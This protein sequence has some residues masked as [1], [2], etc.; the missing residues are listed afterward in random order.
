ME[1]LLS[2]LIALLVY[3]F[4]LLFCL[5]AATTA[6][7]LV[8]KTRAARWFALAA[9]VLLLVAGNGRLAYTLV[10]S[11]ENDY[12]PV[13]VDDAPASDVIIVL[14]GGLG[15]PLP[16]RLY[17][18]L[19]SSSDRLL[20]AF[21]LYRAGKAGKILLSGG[22]VFPQPGLEGESFYARQLLE[23]WGVPP[24]AVITETRSRNTLQNA[25]YSAPILA[26]NGWDDVLLVTSASHMSRAV[27][28][29]R[30][31]GVDVVPIPTDFDAVDADIPEIF[32]WLPTIGALG[33]TTQAVHEYIG[34]VYYWWRT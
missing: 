30:H 19:G 33:G 2:K 20:E 27:L 32:S 17:V 29:F 34:R 7:L 4:G 22:N 24:D 15:L 6:L 8:K 18:D 12:P 11:L 21:R 5:V 16:P 3:P 31:A 28:A 14:G 25:T 26:E 1:I 10:R 13:A 23:L 9:L